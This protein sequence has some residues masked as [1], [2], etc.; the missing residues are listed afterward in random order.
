[1]VPAA[2][3]SDT[4]GSIRLPASA[5]GVLGLKPTHGVLSRYGAMP[6]APSLDTPGLCARSSR[7]LALMLDVLTGHDANDAQTSRR[8]RAGVLAT[9]ETGATRPLA[10]LRIGVPRAY[11]REQVDADVVAA[12]DASL[13]RLESLGAVVVDAEV[14]DST[15]LSELNRVITYA[16]ASAAH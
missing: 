13:E 4:G 14:P 7:D 12:L 3:G 6:L 1:I 9:L 5:C 10:A 8:P 2:L 11:F 15:R 16:E